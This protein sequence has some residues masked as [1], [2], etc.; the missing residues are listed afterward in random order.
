MFCKTPPLK[1]LNDI[2]DQELA[3]VDYRRRE[4]DSQAA[5]SASALVYMR[6]L[7]IL[8]YAGR[9]VSAVRQRCSSVACKECFL[10]VARGRAHNA[11]TP[12][13]RLRRRLH[14]RANVLGD[15]SRK[16]RVR[17]PKWAATVSSRTCSTR[18]MI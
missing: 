9:P 2:L 5:A 10:V 13:T 4:I 6:C 12:S 1:S 15:A 11:G 16:R 7:R 8:L 3:N 14:M 18:C 17:P